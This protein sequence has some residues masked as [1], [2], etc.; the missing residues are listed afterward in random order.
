[1]PRALRSDQT[2]PRAQVRATTAWTGTA[3][4]PA[5]WVSAIVT[6]ARPGPAPATTACSVMSMTRAADGK[7]ALEPLGRRRD[8]GDE[9]AHQRLVVQRLH[10]HL[11]RLEPRRAGIDGR[12]V[13]LHHAFLARIGVDAGETDR[14]RRVAIGADP[15]Q[16]VEHRLARLE[17]DLV[18]LEPP[19]LGVGAA[20][21]LERRRL[22]H[23]AAT[24]AITGAD[25]SAMRPSCR[26]TV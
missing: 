26:R 2:A 19:R 18:A 1:M 13:E 25:A 4:T 9:I 11:A 3:T 12:A 20:P 7:L 23:C 21:H 5:R 14:E 16:P 10:H 15:A 6:T 17:R 8:L 22:A 24:S